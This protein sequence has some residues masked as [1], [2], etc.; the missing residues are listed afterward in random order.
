MVGRIFANIFGIRTMH[1]FGPYLCTPTGPI[2]L[3]AILQRYPAHGAKYVQY[4]L[5]LALLSQH[6]WF[7]D[8]QFIRCDIIVPA[9]VPLSTGERQVIPL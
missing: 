3:A 1:R 4:L 8:V 7:V 9:M 2:L 5:S 6:T